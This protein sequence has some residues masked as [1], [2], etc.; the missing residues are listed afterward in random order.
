LW[1]CLAA[2]R[3]HS[4]ST[5]IFVAV[6]SGKVWLIRAL[7]SAVNAMERSVVCIFVLCLLLTAHLLSQLEKS[8]VRPGYHALK[9]IHSTAGF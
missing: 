6:I 8:L 2:R 5:N 7:L 3:M 9:Y 4:R 1:F